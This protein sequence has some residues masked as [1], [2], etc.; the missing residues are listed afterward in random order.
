[1]AAKKPA[2]APPKPPAKKANP[3]AGKQAPPFAAKG[4]AASK[5]AMPPAGMPKRGKGKGC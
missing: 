2:K 1:M 5:G 4:K 3:F